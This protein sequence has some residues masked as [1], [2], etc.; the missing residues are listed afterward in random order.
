MCSVLRCIVYLYS[1]TWWILQFIV[2]WEYLMLCLM[3][4]LLPGLHVET[5]LNEL[6]SPLLRYSPSTCGDVK[7][8]VSVMLQCCILPSSSNL[9][10]TLPQPPQ[11][12]WQ[13]MFPSHLFE[14]HLCIT[15]ALTSQS[16][17]FFFPCL[18]L[19]LVLRLR[20]LVIDIIIITIISNSHF[21]SRQDWGSKKAMWL[22]WVVMW[23]RMILGTTPS[24][25]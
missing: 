22:F 15:T 5:L 19:S 23:T 10:Y 12:S 17:W 13:V 16:L 6:R 9:T 25:V 4:V 8:L 1:V 21:P 7:H 18:H 14:P 11:V 20:G 24:C 2:S 3:S